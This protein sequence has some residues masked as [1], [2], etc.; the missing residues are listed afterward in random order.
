[1]AHL[2]QPL[3]SLD[4]EF[5]NCRVVLCGPVE[6]GGDDLTLHRALH[7]GD[8][9]GT[10]VHQ[11]NHE[12]NL[13][14]VDGD[15]VGDRLQH[16]RLSR[17]RRRDDKTT[18]ALADRRNQVDHPGD[19]VG[20]IGLQPQS[21]LRVERSQ[22]A[23]LNPVTR[24]L[25]LTAIDGVD[26]DH[27]VELLLLLT[28]PRLSHGAGDRVSLAQSEAPD[29]RQRQVDI[30]AAGQVSG[31]PDERVTVQNVQNSSYRHGD[32]VVSELSFPVIPI[33]P[34]GTGIAVGT[35]RALILESVA[36]AAATTAA[37]ASAVVVEV[38]ASV[39]R[40]AIYASRGGPLTA[41]LAVILGSITLLTVFNRT[42]SVLAICVLA[43]PA[44]RPVAL[45]ALPVTTVERPLA[46]AGIP[47]VG[48]IAHR[49]SRRLVREG[50]GPAAVAE[51][52]GTLLA[53]GTV[54]VLTAAVG[55][56]S[57]ALRR[58]VATCLDG[59]RGLSW[60]RRRGIVA[61]DDIDRRSTGGPGGPGLRVTSPSSSW[62]I[63]TGAGTNGGHQVCFAH[64]GGTGNAE[65]SGERLEFWQEH[66]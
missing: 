61:D 3:G 40:G 46:A 30:V 28:L 48:G 19:H 8:L 33:A 20:R 1:M 37:T 29:H 10:F 53:S 64:T 56:P 41:L 57:R 9:F 26:A 52:G 49:G 43:V 7:V 2:N 25:W 27:R 16:H 18:L 6:G 65:L 39:D 34:A 31:G 4:R 5:G 35:L 24:G 54:A 12:V 17:L 21:V 45:A 58:S 23:E 38:V 55:R 42:V 66:C 11:D 32:I 51:F 15:C 36:S 63:R 59:Q 60:L 14:V 13:W 44:R 22:L 62:T 47:T 50:I